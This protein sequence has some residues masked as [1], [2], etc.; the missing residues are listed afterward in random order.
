MLTPE[1]FRTKGETGSHG[2]L[3][4]VFTHTFCR[5]YRA[6]FPGNPSSCGTCHFTVFLPDGVFT[7]VVVEKLI[8]LNLFVHKS[9][10]VKASQFSS[11]KFLFA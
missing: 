5:T 1:S 7:H 8:Y 2:C 4:F 11:D 3:T 9:L 6:S 10:I